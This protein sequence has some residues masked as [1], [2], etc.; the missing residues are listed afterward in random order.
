MHA[1]ERRAQATQEWER[2]RAC[3]DRNTVA[4][5]GRAKRDPMW[6]FH[7]SIAGSCGRNNATRPFN[8][9]LTRVSTT[10][11]QFTQHHGV[12]RNF[13]HNTTQHT[14]HNTQHT[15]H[16]TQRSVHTHNA[17]PLSPP[18]TAGCRR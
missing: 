17:H 15:T 16:S 9:R 2:T 1:W 5:S 11:G 12:Q 4:S 10:R 7:S 13:T 6:S 14:A 18:Q 3:S 8:H